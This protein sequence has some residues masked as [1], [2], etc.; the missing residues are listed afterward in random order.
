MRR[1][2]EENIS[3]ARLEELLQKQSG[4]PLLVDFYADWCGPCKMLSPILHKLVT[5]PALVG[6]KDVD[7]VTVDV[8]QHIETAQKYG[9][10]AMPTVLAFKEGKLVTSFVGVLPEAK[11]R[12]FI[13]AL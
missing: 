8:D 6:G 2:I 10:R 13:E 7:L 11:L 12:Q 9:I 1:M 4:K 5:T 3:S